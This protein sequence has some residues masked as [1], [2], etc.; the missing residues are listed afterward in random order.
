MAV[1]AD[2]IDEWKKLNNPAKVAVGG[3]GVAAVLLVIS[4]H[5]GGTSTGQSQGDVLGQSAAN[6]PLSGIVTGKPT[7]TP[8]PTTKPPATKPP[9][10]KPPAGKPVVTIPHPATIIKKVT[11]GSKPPTPP[12]KNVANT[13][14]QTVHPI[15]KINPLDRNAVNNHFHRAE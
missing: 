11:G 15:E 5:R 14:A 12:I 7:N 8:G 1:L 13:L 4:M 2:L 6:N 3:V 9:A 10:S